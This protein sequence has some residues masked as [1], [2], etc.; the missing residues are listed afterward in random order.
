MHPTKPLPVH[1]QLIGPP[2]PPPPFEVR[3]R[4]HW[5]IIDGVQPAIPENTP[6][7]APRPAKRPK[8]Q[9]PKDLQPQP[10][11]KAAP[12]A[13]AGKAADAGAGA[14]GQHQQH[15]GP[16]EAGP[17]V[18]PPVQL[19]LSK[20]LLQYWDRVVAVLKGDHPLLEVSDRWL[21]AVR[22]IAVCFACCATPGLQGCW[23]H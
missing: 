7:D 19:L 3:V 12:A 11:A 18:K 5:L 4:P 23:L 16:P 1:A 10:K 8:L 17:H 21:C 15:Q 9:H 2:L 22:L 20:E 6:V 13:A 14:A